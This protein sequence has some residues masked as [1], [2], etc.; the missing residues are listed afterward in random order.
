M[1]DTGRNPG[2]PL[3]PDWFDTVAVNT[4]AAERRAAS[5]TA[6][7]TVKKEWQAAWL[8]NAIR[9][10][11][12]T[13][14]A[15]DDTPAR[16]QRLCAKA[17]QPLAPHILQGLGLEALTTGAVC[18]YP[19][20]VAPAVKALEGSGI[21]VASVAT[22]FPAGLMPLPL[23]LAEIRYAVDQGAAEIDIVISRAHV[24]SGDWQA[25]YDETAAMRE[26][27][28]DAHMKA[29]LATGELKT[30]RNVYKASMVAMQA[31]ADFIKTSTGKEP[32]NA[33]LPVSLVMVRALRD[34]GARTGARVGFK[35]AG[36]MRT[37]KDAIAWQVLMKEEMGNDWLQPDLFRLGASSMLADIE[38][39][40]DHHVTGRY[41]A[42]HRHALA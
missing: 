39:Q 26:A 29:I 18:V 33:T 9:C 38:R 15:G 21:P 28:G 13:T 40:L 23:R 19:T 11:D 7:R 1:T 31:G 35:P 10:I 36:G 27:C 41:A 6:R 30:L 4:P 2:T 32:V 12:L 3:A 20:M 24:L 8:V 14:L 25:L 34:Y 17:R 42:S 16:V 5:L 22:G 37:A